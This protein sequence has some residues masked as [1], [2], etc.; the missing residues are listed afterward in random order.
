[1]QVYVSMAAPKGACYAWAIS[2]VDATYANTRSG[3]LA[4][5]AADFAS[6]STSEVQPQASD[7]AVVGL[8]WRA[9]QPGRHDFDQ[10]GASVGH[11]LQRGVPGACPFVR[12]LALL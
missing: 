9:A 1:M 4:E 10:H 11:C 5:V 7:K 12:P 3:T 8:R 2:S 6:P